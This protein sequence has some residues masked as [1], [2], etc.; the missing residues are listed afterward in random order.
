MAPDFLRQK[1]KNVCFMERYYSYSNYLKEKYGQKVYK[2]PVNLP[3][4]CPNRINGEGCIFCSEQGTGFEAM[5]SSISV[6]EQ[7]LKTKQFIRKK[8]KA[9]KFIAYFQNYTNTFMPIKDFQDRIL[10]ASKVSDVV[11]I[12]ISTR[13]DCIKKEYLDYLLMIKEQTGINI[14]IELGLQSVNYRCLDSINR[15]H[16]LG[17]FLGAVNIIKSYGFNICVHMILNLPFDDMRDVI[18]AADVLSSLEVDIIK[19]HSLYVSKN[20]ILCN[21][22]ENDKITICSASE[23]IERLIVFLERTNSS[24]AIERLFSRIPEEDAVFSNWGI[25]WWKLK[26]MLFKRMEELDTYQG[27]KYVPLYSEALIKGGY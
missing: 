21:M 4:T 17:A 7:L 6:T 8:Y 9:N 10:E 2:L 24:I 16:G 22:Y 15:G 13:P 1:R 12:S 26:D 11:E 25:S 18:E 23:Y 20:T 5:N 14:T 19:L 3:I 27:K